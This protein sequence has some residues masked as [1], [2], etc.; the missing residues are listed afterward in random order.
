MTADLNGRVVVVAG[1]AG[2]AGPP[3]VQAL[4]RAR[5]TVVAVDRDRSLV[6][7][8]A[9]E[10]V[11]PEVCDL[12]DEADTRALA[13]RVLDRHGRVDGLAHLVGGWRGGK[14]IT[15]SDLADWAFLEG[16]LV[17]TLQHT[18]RAFH[19][20]IRKAGGR[21]CIVSSSQAGQPTATN[22]AYAAA[23][24]AAEA[25]TLAVADSFTGSEAAAV[26]LTVKA[27]VTPQMRAAKPDKAFQG[28]TDVGDLATEIC[29]LWEMPAAELN[30]QRLVQI[31]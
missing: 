24:A 16:L 4:A 26:I 7:P 3:L 6:D 9:D 28:F 13:T 1:A 23:K 11:E 14:S 20:P 2:A 18:S 5:A 22:A 31:P 15:E 17:R 8:L 30:G 29:Q 10:R 19:D 25:W 12:L 27:L 21:L